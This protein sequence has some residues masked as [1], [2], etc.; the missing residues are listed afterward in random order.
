MAVKVEDFEFDSK[1]LEEATESAWNNWCKWQ[2]D[3]EHNGAFGEM[4][5]LNS[6][7]RF[8]GFVF[9][10]SLARMIPRNEIETLF[11]WYRDQGNPDT[12]SKLNDDFLSN[13]EESPLKD[14]DGK[15]AKQK[16]FISL[17]S[18]L[19]GMWKPTEFAMWDRYARDGLVQLQRGKGSP[20][21]RRGITFFNKLNSETYKTYNDFFMKVSE[22]RKETLEGPMTKES[23][24]I[25]TDAKYHNAFRNRILDSYLMLEGKKIENAKKEKQT[26][27]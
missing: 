24:N 4:P 12:F 11:D 21:G 19:L 18:K 20:K 1:R 5:V 8:L 7:P 13:L 15:A 22:D 23:V 14:E 26:N 6:L 2:G 25:R 27:G 3:F 16:N 10:Y 9:D 17:N